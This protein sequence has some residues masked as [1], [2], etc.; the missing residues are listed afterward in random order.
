MPQDLKNVTDEELRREIRR[1]QYEKELAVYKERSKEAE[2][3]AKN[4]DHLLGII[5]DHV[6]DGS[7]EDPSGWNGDNCDR[8]KLLDIKSQGV[9]EYKI[10]RSSIQFEWIGKPPVF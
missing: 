9:S 10:D 4:V 2:W 3:V 1:R 7:C 5:T 8:C 6:K